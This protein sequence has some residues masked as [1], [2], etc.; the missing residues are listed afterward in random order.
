MNHTFKV[1]QVGGSIRDELLKIEAKDRDWVVTGGDPEIM[2][3]N[4]FIQ[5]GKDFPVF[6]DP[7]SGEEYALARLERNQSGVQKEDWRA[8]TLKEDLSRRDLTINAMAKDESGVL[9]DYFGGQKDLEDKVLRHIGVHFKEDPLRIFRV[10]RF[11]ARYNFTVAEETEELIKDMVKAGMVQKI[12]RERIWVE[13]SKS[14]KEGKFDLFVEHL[15][16]WKVWDVLKIKV[17]IEGFKNTKKTKSE[18]VEL[19]KLMKSSTELK[20]KELKIPELK[21][22]K[23]KWILNYGKDCVEGEVK[24][25]FFDTWVKRIDKAILV[26]KMTHQVEQACRWWDDAS[27]WVRIHERIETKQ[28]ITKEDFKELLINLRSINHEAVLKGVPANEIQEKLKIEREKV[29]RN[30]AELKIKNDLN[31]MEA[32]FKIKALK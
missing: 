13:I 23:M 25:E 32:Q 17:D 9:I 20:W 24:G 15:N 29:I 8:V 11:A 18:T 7:K 27:E 28:L 22:K 16:R 26:G 2:I 10:G 14:L 3:Q 19:L 30:W 31:C 4:G 5:V 6:L 21:I 12:A 1:Y